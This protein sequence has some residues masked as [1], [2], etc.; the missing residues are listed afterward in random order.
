MSDHF[1]QITPFLHVPDID[2]AVA[3]FVG[4]L[5]FERLYHQPG[6]AYVEREGCG[7]RLLEAEEGAPVDGQDV[8]RCYIDV[9]D[10][11]ALH[12]ELKPQLDTLPPGDVQGPGDKPWGQRELVVR[13]PGGGLVAFGQGI[14]TPRDGVVTPRRAANQSSEM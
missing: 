10:V 5:G 3:F 1:L 9:R 4:V 2:A 14:F 8:Y 6:Y 13:A 11:D 12:A 7:I